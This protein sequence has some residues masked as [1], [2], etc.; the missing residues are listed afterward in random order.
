MGAPSAYFV[1]PTSGTD[2]TVGD[3]G[4]VVG[5]PWKSVQFALD[6]ITR[7]ATDGDVINVKAGG[8]DTLSAGLNYTS[9][10]VSSATS[11]LIVRGYTSAAGDGGIGVISGGGSVGIFTTARSGVHIIDMHL[12]TC[13]AATIFNGGQENRLINVELDNTTGRAFSMSTNTLC[14]NCHFHNFGVQNA[15]GTTNTVMRCV[16]DIDGKTPGWLMLPNAGL[17]LID[18]LL[19][20]G[21][22][23]AC[24]RPLDDT[25]VIGCVFFGAGGTG[26]GIHHN[27][28][29]DGALIL[30]NI[31]E[32]FSGSGGVA[33]DLHAD[34]ILSAYSHNSF[35]DNAT[36]TVNVFTDIFGSVNEV[37]SESPFTNAAGDDFSTPDNVGKVRSEDGGAY[38]SGFKFGDTKLELNR[39]ASQDA[40]QA[41]AVGGGS[42]SRYRGLVPDGGLGAS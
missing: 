13:G 8:T 41:A 34:T 12:H 32:G 26:K 4:T 39:G 38:P 2:D 35:F 36:D 7:D 16:F 20:G 30:N 11:P 37:L 25:K 21:G 42:G 17:C 15:P 3:R 9:Y 29:R 24:I 14:Y 27:G 33:V 28:G 22:A 10:G 18:C 23:T 40:G 31:F 6:S 19:I 5:N 1:D